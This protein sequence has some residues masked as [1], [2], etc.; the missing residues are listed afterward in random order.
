MSVLNHPSVAGRIEK[1]KSEVD[2]YEETIASLHNTIASMKNEFLLLQ[3]R[4]MNY[5]EKV[6]TTL[7][8][9]YKDGDY[10]EDTI[11]G[12]MR[13]LSID[14]M[15]TQKFE[16]NATFVIDVEVALGDTLN[17]DA[18]H[19]DLDFDVKSTEFQ[20]LDF[21]SDIIYANIV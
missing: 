18:L 9:M 6:K 5:A 12:V 4:G 8:D 11:L 16:V 3:N 10:D 19:W 14:T 15:I 21:S 13:N 2:A 20:V 1:L 7:F 17:K